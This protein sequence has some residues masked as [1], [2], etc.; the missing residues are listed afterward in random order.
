MK[1]KD[2]TYDIEFYQNFFSVC[3][4]SF[5][6]KKVKFK[7]E[8]SER[9][10]EREGLFEFLKDKD[11][12][13]IGFNNNHYDYPVLHYLLE[14]PH[15]RLL[16]W[17]RWIQKNIFNDDKFIIWESQRKIKQIDLFKINH[18]DNMAK[19]C[20]LKWLEFTM[21]WHRVQDLPIKPDMMIPHGFIDKMID[22]NWN[23][24]EFTHELAVKSWG[25]V[26][27]RENMSETLGRSV[28]DYSDVK[29]GEY[30]NR[31]KYEELSGRAWKEFKDKRTY[32]S[33]FD[34]VD[35][36]PPSIK[37]YTPMMKE[38]LEELK[39]TQFYDGEPFEKTLKIAG[40]TIKFAKGGLHSVDTPRVQERKEGW[41]LQE[42]DVGS[43][44]PRGI[45]V[46]GIHP[47]HLG[48]E[49]NTG[50]KNAYDYRVNELKPLLKTL[51]YQSDEWKKV[52]DEQEVYKL[53][54]NGGGFGKLGSSYSWQF[55]PL[56]K[57]Q[58]TIGC[59]LKLLM[60]IEAFEM[61]GIDVIS[62]NTDGV[63]IHYPKDKK[64]VVD[65]IHAWWEKAT[66]FL[67]EDTDY[68]QIIF[69]T[70]NDY[71]AE[72]VDPESD[73][74]IKIKYKGDFEI[75][76]DIHKNNSQRIVP[77]ALSQYFIHGVPVSETVRRLG[78]TFVDSKGKEQQTH[79]YDYCIGRKVINS[80]EYYLV[81]KGRASLI[82][83]KVIRYY[84]SKSNKTLLKKFTKGK[85]AGAYQ[86]INAGFFVEP[87]MDY[88]K[89]LEY[90][91]DYLYYISECQKIIQPIE[92]GTRVLH[93]PHAVQG[94]LF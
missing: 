78:S 29:I 23:D 10:D 33:S 52:N 11:L 93:N 82:P 44:Y 3:F 35:I 87:F 50:I 31:K 21:R 63:V 24:V 25:A 79:I 89:K 55:D 46:E 80:C 60:L 74:T 43:M 71:I 45:I 18:F 16:N 90:H 32:R 69:S 77:I 41:I 65:K 94:E 57:Y 38:F 56:A 5:P 88:Q 84:I 2:Y 61:R 37:F 34:L 40:V 8:I 19:R 73:E 4:M 92:S 85:K 48:V 7:F 26:E 27:L 9:M 36:I 14:N 67:L 39:N 59:E 1:F 17:W 62:V 81:D 91:I 51:E 68:K 49:W 70:V 15:T 54:M 42:K 22:Y 64:D 72:I 53:A 76:K 66:D 75:D 12:R 30:L 20:S 6:D 86:K 83:D 13:L 58:V 47:K 28:M